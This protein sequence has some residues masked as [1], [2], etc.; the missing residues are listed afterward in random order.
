MIK[1]LLESMEKRKEEVKKIVKEGMTDTMHL[2]N[3]IHDWIEVQK[4]QKKED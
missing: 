1:K 2:A 4:N 3:D